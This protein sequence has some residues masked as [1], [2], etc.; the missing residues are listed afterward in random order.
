MYRRQRAITGTNAVTVG[1]YYHSGALQLLADMVKVLEERE[2]KPVYPA[3]QLC[4]NV[5]K[6]DD[7]ST[8]TF[9][10]IHRRQSR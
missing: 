3:A 10:P 8:S 9:R 7:Y 5:T 4:R 2:S 1:L 6:V